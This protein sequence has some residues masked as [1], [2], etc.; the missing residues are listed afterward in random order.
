[1]IPKITKNLFGMVLSRSSLVER[2]TLPG[3][4]CQ[5]DWRYICNGD[6]WHP[7]RLHV[8]LA[9][10][11]GK[12][13]PMKNDEN[14]KAHNK[15]WFVLGT[16]S[17]VSHFLRW[18]VSLRYL[19]VTPTAPFGRSPRIIVQD[20]FAWRKCYQWWTLLNF[21]RSYVL[22]EKMQTSHG[23]DNGKSL[24]SQKH[25]AWPSFEYVYLSIFMC[26][27]CLEHQPRKTKCQNPGGAITKEV[28]II[29]TYWKSLKLKSA[30][31][32]TR[33]M[34]YDFLLALKLIFGFKFSPPQQEMPNPSQWPPHHHASILRP[35][36]WKGLR[37]RQAKPSINASVSW[38]IWSASSRWN[39]AT[40]NFGCQ[41]TH[42]KG[43]A[44]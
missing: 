44:T 40:M 36:T 6:T 18:Q 24:R 19:W 39:F 37:G 9:D 34:V 32:K 33:F 21:P 42:R 10:F 15:S 5:K 14:W 43:A 29:E 27:I 26:L 3:H 12:P 22:Q 16:V 41:N 8:E 1:M 11:N 31:K 4:V 13:K 25:V 30:K 20:M 2:H 17:S 28:Y 23:H 7:S 35:A 38:S